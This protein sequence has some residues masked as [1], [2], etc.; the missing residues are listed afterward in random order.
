MWEGL[1]IPMR[2]TPEVGGIKKKLLFRINS[3]ASVSCI[4]KGKKKLHG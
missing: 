4:P 2:R 1:V 3:L